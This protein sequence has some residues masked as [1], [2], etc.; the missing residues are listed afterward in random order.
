M[1]KG[2]T[3][4]WEGGVRIVIV[5]IVIRTYHTYTRNI[6]MCTYY[7]YVHI[8]CIKTHIYTYTENIYTHTYIYVHRK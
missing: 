6:Y 5:V 8:L 4:L 1:A 3:S 2:S 7:I